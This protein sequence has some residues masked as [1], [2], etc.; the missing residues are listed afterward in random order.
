VAAD[1][2]SRVT[3]HAEGAELALRADDAA[4][5]AVVRVDVQVGAPSGAGRLSRQ[6]LIEDASVV[7]RSAVPDATVE[8]RGPRVP[9]PRRALRRRPRWPEE[10]E[11]R[12]FSAVLRAVDRDAHRAVDAARPLRADQP[13]GAEGGGHGVDVVVARERERTAQ[14]EDDP[15]N[16]HP[17][18]RSI[19]HACLSAY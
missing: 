11:A 4:A 17:A 2:A 18:E 14:P 6:A 13:V 10:V 12:R 19:R 15:P 8:V 16:V 9:L 5:A 7:P 3:A 1:D